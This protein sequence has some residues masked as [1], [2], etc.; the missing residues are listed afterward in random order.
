[1]ILSFLANIINWI[2]LLIFVHPVDGGIIL[3][4]NVYFGVDE[5]GGSKQIFIMPSTGLI[6]F[7]I[8]AL[9]ASYFY[10]QK[11]RIASYILL[12]TSI[13]AQMSLIIASVSVIIINY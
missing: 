12:L 4:Y 6:L 9:L 2:I 5:A 11:E 8:N 1:M 13:M 10:R 3:H 7:V